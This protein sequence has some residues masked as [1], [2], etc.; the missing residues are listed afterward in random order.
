VPGKISIA[1][2]EAARARTKA[3]YHHGCGHSDAMRAVRFACRSAG[4]LTSDKGRARSLRKT[5]TDLAR[6]SALL[7][8]RAPLSPTSVPWT[9]YACPDR[10]RSIAYLRG[11]GV[12]AAG[13]LERLRFADTIR[14][15]LTLPD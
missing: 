11:R 15:K 12:Y 4:R 8:A 3:R 10:R 7:S 9:L 14:S 13:V 5:R 6:A 1:R 2:E